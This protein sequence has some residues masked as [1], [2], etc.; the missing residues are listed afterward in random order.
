MRVLHIGLSS[1]MGGI[2][3]FSLN[4]FAKL[5]EY[6]VIFD[7]ADIYGV[8]IAEDDRIE[9]FGGKILTLPNYK[10]YPLRFV[11]QMTRI[12]RENQYDVVH[13]NI[14]T[15]AN[16]LPLL[17]A[18]R[19]GI[20][21]VVHAHTVNA[22]GKFRFILHTLN[23]GHLR[24]MSSIHLACSQR[25]G[26]WLWKTLDFQVIPNAIDLNQFAFSEENRNR[27]RSQLS[28]EEN[29]ILWGYVGRLEPVK[30]PLFVVRLFEQYAKAYPDS[31]IKLVILGEGSMTAQIQNEIDLKGLEDSVIMTGMQKNVSQFLSAMDIFLMPSLHEALGL[32]GVEAQANGLCCLFADTISTDLKIIETAEFLPLD[33]MERWTQCISALSRKPHYGRIAATEI[34]E[35]TQFNINQSAE[36]LLDIYHTAMRINGRTV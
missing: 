18:N 26:E 13:I 14:Q 30:N 27:V 24:K 35:K 19:A 10:K 1:I 4:Y 29:V 12:L 28:I 5:S 32:A 33:D 11:S 9:A 21:P 31:K 23:I 2:E 16:I 15:A 22:A 36:T 6:G 7:Y 8:G 34:V 25:A 20:T 17:A 3:S